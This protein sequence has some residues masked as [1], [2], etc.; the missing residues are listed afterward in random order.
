LSGW[1]DRAKAE[2]IANFT[3]YGGAGHLIL[4][5]MLLQPR[6]DKLLLFPAWP[7]E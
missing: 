5:N 2:V 1:A 3:A 4:Q 6:G 7:R